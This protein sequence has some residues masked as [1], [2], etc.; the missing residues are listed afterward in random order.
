MKKQE[1][2]SLKK[3][4]IEYFRDVPVQK[5]AAMAIARDEDTIIRWR[6]E[7]TVFADALLKAKA[8]WVRKR[9]ILTRAEYAL[10]RLEKS[11]FSHNTTLTLEKSTYDNFV[12]NNQI[13]PN[14]P[15]SK[16]LVERMV[17]F[18]ME[19]TKAK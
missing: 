9:L 1:I 16:A 3:E 8:D 5:Y 18:L 7:D 19:E 6:K 2:A 17:D 11:I 14:T 13:D 10:D 12:A 4:Y 15:N